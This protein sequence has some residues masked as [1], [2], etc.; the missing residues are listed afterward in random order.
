MAHTAGGGPDKERSML[1]T[2]QGCADVF[3]WN[4]QKKKSEISNLKTIT[5]DED[6]KKRYDDAFDL[7]D[8][9]K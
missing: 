5:R 8:W 6:R 4:M 9:S 3:G 7:I 2:R 1:E